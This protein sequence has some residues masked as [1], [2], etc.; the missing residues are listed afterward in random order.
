VRK[1]LDVKVFQTVKP[2]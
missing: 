2:V 1:T